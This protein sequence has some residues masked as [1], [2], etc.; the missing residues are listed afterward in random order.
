MLDG[1]LAIVEIMGL[2]FFGIKGGKGILRIIKLYWY[3]CEWFLDVIT[4]DKTLILIYIRWRK[5][6]PSYEPAIPKA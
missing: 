6:Y 3:S 4:K 1:L 5:N 2:V